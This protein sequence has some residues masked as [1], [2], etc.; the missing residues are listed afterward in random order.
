[1]SKVMH[2]SKGNSIADTKTVPKDPSTWWQWLLVYPTL[3]V[4]LLT[5][6]PTFVEAWRSWKYDRVYAQLA[7]FAVCQ[8][9]V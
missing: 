4:A 9:W 7:A 5:S 1:M 8:R 2:Q 6:I 3:A